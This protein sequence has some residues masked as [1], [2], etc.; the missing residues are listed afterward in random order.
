MECSYNVVL[1]P[2][3]LPHSDVR[4]RNQRQTDTEHTAVEHTICVLHTIWG[5]FWISAHRRQMYLQMTLGALTES[6]TSINFDIIMKV[7]TS[8]KASPPAILYWHLHPADWVLNQ[9]LGK[10]G[11]IFKYRWGSL[12]LTV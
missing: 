9:D 2:N 11:E 4:T 3:L 12:I 8:I 5:Y 7:N 10:W 1:T 6:Q